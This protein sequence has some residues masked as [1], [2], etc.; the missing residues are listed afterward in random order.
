MKTDTDTLRRHAAA[1]GG[2]PTDTLHI[3]LDALRVR[4]MDD[5]ADKLDDDDGADHAADLYREL[6]EGGERAHVRG[7]DPRRGEAFDSSRYHEH[8]VRLKAWVGKPDEK[9][10]A[11]E[12]A[13]Q[14]AARLLG[15]ISDDPDVMAAI[16]KA[17][18]ETASDITETVRE[19]NEAG[20]TFLR[21]I[22]QKPP[23]TFPKGSILVVSLEDET[24]RRGVVKESTPDEVTIVFEG[25]EADEEGCT[26]ERGQDRPH[27]DGWYEIN[28]SRTAV[29]IDYE[30]DENEPAESDDENEGP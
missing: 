23:V 27:G 18:S 11:L 3:V 9:T 2:L 7:L 1:L 13:H 14:S 8:K 10:R 4:A 24:K 15:E 25:D 16:R 28:N 26:F 29:Q 12:N 17:S 19:W 21:S 30:R 5:V 22:G 6:A 20:E